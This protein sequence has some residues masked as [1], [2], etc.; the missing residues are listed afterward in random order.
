VPNL[1]DA[2]ARRA[3]ARLGAMRR[4][5]MRRTTA[6]AGASTRPAATQLCWRTTEPPTPEFEQHWK[7]ALGE[8]T[9]TNF[10]L[11]F[12]YL[13]WEARHGRS[14]LAVLSEGEGR[15]G[16][17]V[18][19]ETRAG[20]VCG[21][22]WRWAAVMRNG[23]VPA[24]TLEPAD[25]EWLFR[26]AERAAAGRRVRVYQ[27]VPPPAARAGFAA[28]AT[29]VQAVDR[30]DDEL[31]AMMQAS[32][33]RMVKR[34]LQE[35]YQ[36]IQGATL[37]QFHTFATIQIETMSRRGLR[38]EA[39]PPPRP[40]PGEG[41]REWELPWM[42]LL[43]AE[44]DGKIESG[45]GDGVRE[46]G[47]VEGRTG[48]STLAGRRA[49]AFALL[50]YEE[51]RRARERGF[52]WVNHGGDTPFKREMAGALGIRLPMYCWLGGGALWAPAN[53]SETWARQ[54]RLKVPKWARAI[55]GQ[56]VE[57]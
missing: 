25:A 49:G 10:T 43:L 6:A 19:R 32:K 29:I 21:W 15:K 31:M 42:W 26:Q 17:L 48:A 56:G 14:A 28:G 41:W 22:P 39:T 45:L 47:M 5:R 12:A 33:R 54:V 27:P 52:R 13:Q 23:P 37:E 50:C 3:R 2:A 24:P 51:A 36:V 18:L 38:V 46:G 34:A 4:R 9:L 35:G 44:R 11:D 20:Y 55:R 40:E 30:S 53:R 16:M 1:V 8:A 57:S 7:R